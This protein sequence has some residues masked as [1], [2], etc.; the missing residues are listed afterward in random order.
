MAKKKSYVPRLILFGNEFKHDTLSILGGISEQFD[1]C[2]GDF[3]EM[4]EASILLEYVSSF[5]GDYSKAQVIY[6]YDKAG[7]DFHHLFMEGPCFEIEGT[8]DVSKLK[9]IQ[10]LIK[11]V[12][13]A[14]DL[15]NSLSVIGARIS[16]QI[17][18]LPNI[19]NKQIFN[20]TLASS[21]V[22][23]EL[24][25]QNAKQALIDYMTVNFSV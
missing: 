24:M 5:K 17:K 8:R 22:A 1:L 4:E 21:N 13:L 3:G 23:Q 18:W 16:S 19:S 7:L 14:E 12:V 2:E 9:S 6:A 20:S 15:S 10:H 25:V 11:H